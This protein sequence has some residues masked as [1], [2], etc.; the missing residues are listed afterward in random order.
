MNLQQCCIEQELENKQRAYFLANLMNDE[1]DMN[2]LRY[3]M[4]RL[5]TELNLI[6]NQSHN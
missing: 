5:R 1:V 4:R 6:K 3:E 2:R